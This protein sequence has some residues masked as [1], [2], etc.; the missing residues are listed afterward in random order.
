MTDKPRLSW[1]T[2]GE[3]AMSA[4]YRIVRSTRGMEIWL[5][6]KTQSGCLA[7]EIATMEQAKLFCERH[8]QKQ[9]ETA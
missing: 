7:R 6:S 9:R 3:C 8:A 2:R 5:F 4:P 1:V